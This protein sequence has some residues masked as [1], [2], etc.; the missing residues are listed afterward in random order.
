MPFLKLNHYKKQFE[1]IKIAFD[2][3]A[4]DLLV[5]VV[6]YSDNPQKNNDLYDVFKFVYN[7]KKIIFIAKENEVAQ[8][9]EK[10]KNSFVEHTDKAFTWND[11][12]LDS[13]QK[14]LEKK[15]RFL[16]IDIPLNRLI[17]DE[18]AAIDVIDTVTLSELVEDKNKIIVGRE[19]FH[20]IG[21]N[22]NYYIPRIFNYQTIK[23]D[24]FEAN[25]VSDLFAIS[26]IDEKQFYN[27]L[28]RGSKIRSW[29]KHDSDADSPTRFIL[30][31]NQDTKYKDDED[32][33][34]VFE[35]LHK[36]YPGQTIH[37]LQ[38]QQ[39]KL[40]WKQSLGSLYNLS[41]YIDMDNSIP[42]ANEADFFTSEN[43]H[44]VVIIANK[45]GMGKST[46]LTSLA[47]KIKEL[48]PALWVFRI[49][50]NDYAIDEK[51]PRSL[52]N[53]NFESDETDK[54]IAFL[55]TMV[56]T[57]NSLEK[58]LFKASFE[59]SYKIVI[60]FDC[61]DEISP[62]YKEK[63]IRLLEA[64]RKTAVQQLWITTRPHMKS[65]LENNLNIFAYFLKSFSEN[66]QI[67]FLTRFWKKSL[68]FSES[69]DD[70]TENSEECTKILRNNLEKI[71]SGFRQL[72]ESISNPKDKESIQRLVEEICSILKKKSP[73][74]D[75]PEAKLQ[76]L[77]KE[78]DDLSLYAYAQMLLKRLSESIRD[79]ERELTSIPLQIRML[80]EVVFQ[81]KFE[82]PENLGLFELYTLFVERKI[83]IYIKDKAKM[84]KNVFTQAI[85]DDHL[86][87]L[88]IIYQNVALKELF[89]EQNEKFIVKNVYSK[90]N[91]NEN[92][93]FIRSGLADI[94]NEKHRFIHH[95]F[96][97]YFIAL[98]LTINLQD[99]QIQNLL[100]TRI[101]ILQDYAVIR[102][103]FNGHLGKS[104]LTLITLN[105][106]V[107]SLRVLHIAAKESHG[108][109]INILLHTF[110]KDSKTLQ[111]LVVAK[112]KDERTALQLAA[113]SGHDKVVQQLLDFV[114]VNLEERYPGTIQALVMA[115]DE[116]KR[117]VLQLAAGSDRDK[118]IHKLLNFLQVNLEERY[119]GTLQALI[120][121]TDK[122]E[123]NALQLAAG[124]GHDKVVQQLLN[125][126][127]VNLEERY[128]G[129]L[130][131]LIF[132]TDKYERNALKLVAGR[133][134]DKVVQQLLN[135]VQVNL[136]ERYPGTLQTLVVA[137]DEDERTVLQ[138][139]AK[140]GDDK[141]IQQLL[142][143]VQVNLEERYSGSLLALILSTDNYKQN[144]LHLAA[145]IGH[146]E[147]VQK[148]LNF[149]QVNLEERY[150]G[151]LL[152]LILAT[153]KY[154]RNALQLAAGSGCDKVFQQLMDFVQVN[155]EERYPRTLQALVEAKNEND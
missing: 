142:N 12:T 11:L 7:Q 68:K 67:D 48:S 18:D 105:P 72:T 113:E 120:L 115:K 17:K 103:F 149:V 42:Y 35:K 36:P 86:T 47:Y 52:N 112:D 24:I 60:L 39:D 154:K 133:G 155:L 137:K 132:A 20:S 49:N 70:P 28:P 77:M 34:K 131:D 126:V 59:N 65:T 14:L 102:L 50:L 121:A 25:D 83:E 46:L 6:E 124:R 128:P 57:K 41:K 10:I 54:A 109:I 96:A 16:G 107:I 44:K 101:L 147:V 61:F 1:E 76:R 130:Q 122:Y 153:D 94:S 145:E 31:D 82:L 40:V 136:E 37:W 62:T 3:I 97:E 38:Y 9:K 123:L 58:A 75:K 15:I 45:A 80:A 129:T 119:P 29:D 114:Q 92:E 135:F 98:W 56:G 69:T 5:L 73:E 43:R 55:S 134:H 26:D 138:L 143:F 90:I 74:Q 63:V 81:K 93:T 140:I 150:P 139:A 127:Q 87:S 99:E 141:V 118:V 53:I 108:F 110:K 111:D 88:K 19:E 21:Y 116:D 95:T 23:A 8:F 32:T 66:E 30:L 84:Q 4:S 106:N 104:K 2:S 91:K 33:E 152:V 78:I 100:L 144:A 22:K 51:N 117:T 79:K 151:T 125:F 71:H 13:Q 146:V 64:L 89:D 27:L 148:L 85:I